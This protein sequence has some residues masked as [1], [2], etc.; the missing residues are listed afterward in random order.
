MKKNSNTNID[1]LLKIKEKAS[2]NLSPY[3]FTQNPEDLRLPTYYGAIQTC[4]EFLYKDSDYIV[5]LLNDNIETTG[6]I[7]Q[8]VSD[9]V[10]LDLSDEYLHLTKNHFASYGGQM[11]TLQPHISIIS[12]SE[13]ALTGEVDAEEIGQEIKFKITSC[14]EVMT[15]HWKNVGRV[16]ILK[17]Y[18]EELENIRKKYDLCPKIHGRDFHI[19]LSIQYENEKKQDEPLLSIL[20]TVYGV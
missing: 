14:Y 13:W 2:S 18:S 4:K 17:V 19:L 9:Q 20:P 6:V 8:T 11:P 10:Y 7:K 15:S 3:F 12:P 5:R 1:L 16:W